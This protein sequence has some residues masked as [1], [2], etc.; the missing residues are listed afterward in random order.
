MLTSLE[1]SSG[2]YSIGDVVLPM[3]GTGTVFPGNRTAEKLALC[4]MHEGLVISGINVY[5]YIMQIRI[6][7]LKYYY[8]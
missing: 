4:L 2:H 3:V 7:L 8:L 6:T 1:A 5:G